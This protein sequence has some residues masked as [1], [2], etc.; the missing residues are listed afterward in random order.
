M[1]RTVLPC[2]QCHLPV[3]ESITHDFLLEVCT[4]T[5]MMGCQCTEHTLA[6][7]RLPTISVAAGPL[8]AIFS[9]S[10]RSICQV[11]APRRFATS[12][13]R[14]AALLRITKGGAAAATAQAGTQCETDSAWLQLDANT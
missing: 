11:S 12:D 8:P 1:R 9:S 6:L 7:N 14:T 3:R 2:V 13:I 5:P 4:F 10:G